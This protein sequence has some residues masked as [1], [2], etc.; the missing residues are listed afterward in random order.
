MTDLRDSPTHRNLAAAFERESQNATRYL[1]F[2]KAADID[3]QPEAATL[4]RSLADA[5]T[6]HSHA[7]LEHLADLG[8]PVTGAPIGDTRDNLGAA[9]AGESQDASVD[10]PHYAAIARKEG[11]A[12]VADWFDTLARAEHNHVERLRATLDALD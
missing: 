12:A 11:H 8:D 3:G 7:L 5:E 6:G 4:F 1:W 2:A 9:I 10:Y